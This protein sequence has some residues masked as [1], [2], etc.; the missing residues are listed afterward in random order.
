MAAEGLRP[1]KVHG[2]EETIPVYLAV[3]GHDATKSTGEAP[4]RVTS[5]TRYSLNRKTR[6]Y[7]LDES[8]RSRS[9]CT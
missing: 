9:G 3:D 1:L 6:S 4:Q 2:L 7:A 5:V 8:R